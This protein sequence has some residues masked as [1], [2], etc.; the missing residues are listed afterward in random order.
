RILPIGNHHSA[1]SWYA[2]ARM[3]YHFLAEICPNDQFEFS[4]LCQHR[5]KH[6]GLEDIPDFEAEDPARRPVVFMIRR[7]PPEDAVKLKDACRLC[8][9]QERRSDCHKLRVWV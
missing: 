2:Y 5:N 6:I 4:W 1:R 8:G 3:L 9:R 7:L